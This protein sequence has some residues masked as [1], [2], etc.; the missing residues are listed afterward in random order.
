M[1]DYSE[2]YAESSDQ[3]P[4]LVKTYLFHSVVDAKD[5]YLQ[6]YRICMLQLMTS[7]PKYKIVVLVGMTKIMEMYISQWQFNVFLKSPN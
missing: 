3:L 6:L 4:V 5:L 7:Y 2:Q 1:V